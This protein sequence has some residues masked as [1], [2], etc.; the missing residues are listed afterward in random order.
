S[1]DVLRGNPRAFSYPRAI[2]SPAFWVD[3]NGSPSFANARF[4]M[5]QNSAG[6]VA[7]AILGQPRPERNLQGIEE[8][9]DLGPASQSQQHQRHPGRAWDY[10]ARMFLKLPYS[11]LGFRLR[12]S[13]SRYR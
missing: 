9:I 4:M 6:V 11:I 13:R 8:C 3:W 7:S 1:A 10:S 5:A 2:G 12:R